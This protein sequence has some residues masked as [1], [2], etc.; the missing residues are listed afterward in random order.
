MDNMCLR[1]FHYL[2]G[3]CVAS[4]TAGYDDIRIEILLRE[5][6]E[7]ELKR[8]TKDGQEIP[9]K[10]MTTDHL[11]NVKK[12]IERFE[13]AKKLKKCIGKAFLDELD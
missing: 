1:C 11:R 12:M 13:E 10:D 6:N 7:R 3:K 5:R 9:I 2:D 8:V 4:K